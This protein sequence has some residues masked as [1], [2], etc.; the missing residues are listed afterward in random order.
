MSGQEQGCKQAAAWMVA[1]LLGCLAPGARSAAAD[2]PALVLC[3]RPDNDLCVVLQASRVPHAR[4]DTPAQAVQAAAAGAGVLLLA[5]GYPAA[6]TPVDA[7]LFAEAARKKLRVYVE[8][9]AM[10]PDLSI[11]PARTAGWERTVVAS[12]AFGP[13]LARMR[14][15][16]VQDCRFL[17]LEAAAP[18]LVLAR[19]AG[20]NTAAFGL[21]KDNVWPML[22]EHPRGN[23]LVSTTKLSQF[24]TAR[25]APADAWPAVWR[26]ILGWVSAGAAVP[27]LKWTPTVRPSFG[28]TERL[29]RAAGRL[30]VARGV[31]WYSGGRLLIH[32]DWQKLMDTA[33]RY[34][35]RT[36]PGPGPDLPPGDGT[37]GL[38]EA[39][40]SRIDWQGRQPVRWFTRADC[41]S[42]AAMALALR[43]VMDGDARSKAV[44]TNLLDFVLL[45]S[46]LQQGPRADPASPCYGLLGWDTRP[47]GAVVHYGDDNAR[48][49]LGQVAVAC[50]LKSDRW[51]DAILRCALAN[52]RLTGPAG[53]Q[54]ARI[55]EPQ[56]L[57][58]GWR[59]YWESSDGRWGGVRE[60]PHYQAY[61]WAVRLWLYDKTRFAPLLQRTERALR[62]MMRVYP[63]GWQA[64]CAREEG[65][66]CRMLLPL[67]W[68]VRVADTP[69]HRGWLRQ[70]AD[71]VLA[72]QDAA[73]A[74][75]Q[76]VTGGGGGNESYGTGECALIHANGDPSTDL[77]YGGNFGF[78]GLHEAAAATGDADLRAA[79]AKLADF[80]IRAQVRS[81]A[82]AELDGAWFRGFDSERWD[83][84][85]SNGDIGWGVWATETGWTQG[86]I[87]SVLAMRELKTSFWELTQGSQIAR[88]FDA[89][90]S[91]M[92]PDEAL[93]ADVGAVQKHAALGKPLRLAAPPSPR[94]PGAGAEGLVDGLAAAAEPGMPEW[95]GWEGGD[96]DAT[97]DLGAPVALRRVAIHCLQ[98]RQ[99][100]V[101]LPAAVTI[102]VSD[103]GQTF[104]EAAV[105]RP[106]A[107]T[108]RG[109]P[110]CET[111]EATLEAKARF[112]RVHASNVGAIPGPHPAAGRPAW[113]F[114][115]EILVNPQGKQA[116]P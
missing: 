101:F 64:E 10:L 41:N 38:L 72:D 99:A 69:E 30:A 31:E 34:H 93:A 17:P 87:A 73:G 74:I 111:L 4:C 2:A 39:Y 112:V 89:V 58:R 68:L 6:T 98:H 110:F 113:L 47:E 3:G 94:Y 14:L 91:Q 108:S 109:V 20:Y 82:R 44:A 18:H 43:S 50:A 107:P 59:W 76:R 84:W 33:G 90:R 11:G 51:D 62:H 45:R 52:F 23:L 85:G 86:W 70:V 92:L 106:R 46:N 80:M 49:I 55:D 95:L 28:K 22:F 26:M 81:S 67:A 21:P 71:Y 57:E 36:G 32:P 83:Y 7:A 116:A 103:D 102:G 115:D 9:P 100:G 1:C 8:Y 78:L 66:R 61:Q 53:F 19:V 42:E 114:V 12:D 65:E 96:L 25:Y 60:C 54:T 35:D 77:L 79:A 104:R 88:H 40:S 37:L 27:E 29:P 13:E 48:A 16:M 5:D 75:R 15:L 24:V 63:A 56:L 97:I 105:A